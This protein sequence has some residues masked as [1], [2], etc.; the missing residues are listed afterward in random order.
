MSLTRRDA[1][2]LAGLGGI[3]V[4]GLTVPLGSVSAKRASGLAAAN[5]PVPYRAAFHRPPVLQPYES[6]EDD[7][8]R[9]A[10]YRVV[11][12]A[13]SAQIL[14]GLTTPVFGYNGLVPGPTI[15]VE[16]GTRVRLD[17]YNGLP[18]VHPEFGYPFR[19]S[20]HLHGS[21]SLP[22]YD[23]F[24]DDMT[25]P[26]YCK[27]YRYPNFQT[28]RTLWYHDHAAHET[29][30]NAYG[31]LAAQYHLHDDFERGQLPQGEFDVPL[32]LSDAM[33]A[34][35]GR[36]AVDDR[37]SGLWGDVILVNGR[38]WPTMKVKP[39]LYR[40]R[41]L[42]GSLS[43]AYRPYLST[44]EP[45]TVV[46]TDSG[47]M[48][49]PQPLASYRHGNGE[50]YEVLIDFSGY[51]PGQL[52]QLLNDDVTNNREY[53]HTG[54]ILQFEVLEDLDRTRPRDPIPTRLDHGFETGP[55]VVD[56][57]LLTEDMATATRRMRVERS[58]GRW[59]INGLVWDDIVAGG[60]TEV[61]ANP[62][63]NDI[64]IWE[65]E[66]SSGGW[67]HP[68][69]IHLVDFQVLSR[70]GG[71]PFAWE[72]GPKDVVYV[73]ENETVRLLM[74]FAPGAGNAGGRYMIHCHNLLHED[75]DMMIQ[76]R[77]GRAPDGEDP[78]DPVLADPPHLEDPPDDVAAYGE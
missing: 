57:M 40:F 74:Q 27:Q 4:A 71:A 45:L 50:R 19:I 26:G 2:K 17:M 6:G 38:P 65:I 14:P 53:E 63:V 24:A 29:A 23:G 18:A 43:R 58:N 72:R 52:V 59:A 73:G 69:H 70:N 77:V 75:D 25:E 21:A 78:N 64:E 61:F 8:G 67:F 46:A 48:P 33:F 55:G 9:F 13:A 15:R 30:Y 28:A 11:A 34:A 49:Q 68:M 51:R 5:F 22:Q 20:T 35:D 37:H 12:Q 42:N 3:A 39:Q 76:Y 10:A 60:Y 32:T 16:Q 1:L 54:K 41:V 62:D 31:G 44:G 66:N 56:T 47:L 7:E 36:L